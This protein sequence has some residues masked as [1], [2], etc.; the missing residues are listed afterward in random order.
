[1]D[2]KYDLNWKKVTISDLEPGD[3]FMDEDD[4]L[5]MLI[6]TTCNGSNAVALGLYELLRFEP[7]TR[8]TPYLKS[9]LIVKY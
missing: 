2:I 9:Q 4:R 6:R 8:V 7:T 3:I 1:M 5:C